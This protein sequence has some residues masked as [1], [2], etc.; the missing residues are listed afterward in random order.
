MM[1]MVVRH[2]LESTVFALV[3]ALLTLAF[4]ANGAHVRFWLWF[5]ASVKFLVPFAV[6]AEVGQRLRW[7][8]APTV[9]LDAALPMHLGGFFAQ[10]D[11]F[12]F[13]PLT[14]AIPVF[15]AAPQMSLATV[16]LLAWGAGAAFLLCR[17]ALQWLKL[18]A[19]VKAATPAPI[20]APIP[21]RFSGSLYEPGLVGL[22]R[23]TLLLP[24]GI[25]GQLKPEQLA[26]VI[27][28]EL[29]HW[30]RHDNLTLAIHMLVELLFWFHPL[31]WWVGL[32]LVAEREQACDEAV[33]A[34]GTD[35]GS[36]ANSIL[37]VCRFYVRSPLAC[38]S[39]VAG[40]SLKHRVERIM[41]DG[42]L[43]RL[44]GVKLTLLAMAAAGTLLV[45]AAVGLFTSRP[46]VAQAQSA[47]SPAAASPVASVRTT[48]SPGTE[49]MLRRHIAF[50]EKGQVNFEDMAP[51]LEKAA[52]EQ[53]AQALPRFQKLGTFKTLTFTGVG[54][55]GID[56][57]E[58][59]F[60]NGRVEFRIAPLQPDGKVNGLSYS[61]LPTPD[62]EAAL[63]ARIVASKPDPE[64]EA[65]LRQEIEG[66]QK[67]EIRPE[68]R[69][70]ALTAGA[71]QQWQQ[72]QQNNK[73]LGKFVSLQFLHV[74]SR[75]WDVYDATY[76][77]GH[78]IY[79]VG[80]L[81]D[82]KLNGLLGQG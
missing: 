33:V 2:L 27:E 25:A 58:A 31:V 24:N 68:I 12:A 49:A 14:T 3:M 56:T 21:V 10:G 4:S 54:M 43:I 37:E 20:D 65:L 39:G 69:T 26:L 38:A 71:T 29:C 34:R 22:F 82:H 80:P 40:A 9:A 53:E 19:V 6:I 48:A 16:L 81:I 47:T 11:A 36:Y 7:E 73:R 59:A 51:A 61:I 78:M 77:N 55:G 28:H 1:A 62:E 46:A 42:K 23:P 64:R 66:Q 44:S 8:S 50:L 17:W 70:P 41:E 15:P 13:A 57:Y 72:I 18:R 32:R 52:R 79:R 60:A 75:G 76:E 63:K 45:P 5:A 67:G 74:D 35:P 30:R